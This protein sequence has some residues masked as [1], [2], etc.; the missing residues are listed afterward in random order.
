LANYPSRDGRLANGVGLDTPASCIKILQALAT[1]G[2]TLA[3][4]P[5]DSDDLIRHLTAG[6]TNDP[7]GQGWRPV[8]QVLP[9]Q[10]YQR[11]FARL[12]ASVQ[13]DVCTRWGDPPTNAIPVSGIQLG[14]IFVGLQPSRGYDKDPSLSYHAPDLVPPHEYLAFYA[15]IRFEWDAHAIVH[16]GKHGNLEW[17]PGKGVALS[18]NCFPEVV[19]GPL[20]HFYPF[21]VNDPGEGS[22]AKRR[23]QAVILD[24]LTPPLTRAELY[25]SLLQLEALVD[26]Y[27]QAESLDP[28]R[29]QLIQTQ[30]LHLIQQ[31][32]LSLP[33]RQKSGNQQFPE[34]LTRLDAYLCELKEAQIRDGLHILGQVPQGKQAVDL[35]AALARYPGSGQLGLT[36]AIA[37]DWG[38]E[39]DPLTTDLG[40]RFLQ[41]R[42][43]TAKGE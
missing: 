26:E 11:F 39:I 3:A 18:A 17:L 40:D 42:E 38:L 36:Q 2:Y 43:V 10:I 28:Q 25:G 29:T 1:A 33:G 32:S 20:P 21:I 22:Q 24:H 12:P 4:I 14:H 34:T 16:V 31:E 35:L 27:A 6:V 19:L 23:T 41:D 15:W 9:A 37:Q 5:A 7:M 30:I 13:A 8:K